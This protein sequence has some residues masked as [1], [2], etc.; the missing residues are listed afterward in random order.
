MSPKFAGSSVLAAILLTLAGCGGAG[1]SEPNP[2]SLTQTPAQTFTVSISKA[3]SFTLADAVAPASVQEKTVT[4]AWSGTGAFSAPPASAT[5]D[6]EGEFTLDLTGQTA[7]TATLTAT[8]PDGRTATSSLSVEDLPTLDLANGTPN[9][10]VDGSSTVTATV[11]VNG[12]ASSGRTV[13]WT[14]KTKGGSQAQQTGDSAITDANGQTAYAQGNSGFTASAG[15][16]RTITVTATVDGVSESVDVQFGAALPAGF[17]VLSPDKT[18]VWNDAKTYCTTLGGKL[19]RVANSESTSASSP[20]DGFGAPGDPW[21]A[22]LPDETYWTGTHN[23]YFPLPDYY[24]FGIS[25]NSSGKVLIHNI[26]STED[27]G[28]TT[29]CVP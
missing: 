11:R 17:I 9:P 5:T 10:A 19:P 18:M 8:L 3:A 22:E 23:S 24:V 26:Y 1:S 12:V 6:A 14:W 25:R 21:P 2:V 15:P 29:S 7:G 16:R 28:D 13:T 27:T 20:I 4:L